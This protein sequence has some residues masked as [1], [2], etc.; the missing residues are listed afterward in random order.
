MSCLV[1]SIKF[2]GRVQITV[3]LRVVMDEISYQSSGGMVAMRG[4]SRESF[5][6]VPPQPYITS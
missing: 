3:E 4:M 5:L 6:G 2:V 1:L